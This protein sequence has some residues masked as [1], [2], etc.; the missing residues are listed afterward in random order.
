MH[1]DKRNKNKIKAPIVDHD[2]L[3]TGK[4]LIGKIANAQRELV[5]KE[6]CLCFM[7]VERKEL[8]TK[9]KSMFITNEHPNTKH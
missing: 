9:M 3:I 6:L 8:T 7:V 2:P 1:K 4:T 5:I